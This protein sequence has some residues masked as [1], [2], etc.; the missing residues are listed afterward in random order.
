MF[1]TFAL[2][3]MRTFIAVECNIRDRLRDLQQEIIDKVYVNKNNLNL[4]SPNNMHFTLSFLGEIKESQLERIKKVISEIKFKKI[5]VSYNGIGVFPSIKFVKVIWVGIDNEGSKA[6]NQLH[7]LVYQK[8]EQIGIKTDERFVPHLT[9]IR[10]K[11]NLPN[12][13]EI[14]KKYNKEEF[15]RDLIDKLYVKKSDLTPNGPI[16]SNLLTIDAINE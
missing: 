9:I 1:S 10:V 16:Y 8:L 5:H 6:L 2:S 15:G 4:V 12:I 11:T 13:D 7:N 3:I 14:C